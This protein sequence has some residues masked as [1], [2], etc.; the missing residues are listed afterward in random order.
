MAGQVIHTVSSE[1]V[2]NLWITGEIL[3]IQIAELALNNTVGTAKAA[4]LFKVPTILTTVAEKSFSGPILPEIKAVFPNEPIIDRTTM[5]TWEDQRVRD[6][7][8][9]IGK[10]KLVIAGLWTE[11]CVVYPVVSAIEDGYDVYFISDASGATSME[12]HNMAIQRMVQSGAKPLT[13]LQ[14]LLE[15]QRDWARGATYNGVAEIAKAHGGAYG[16][17]MFYAKEMFN[18]KEGK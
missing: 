12:A 8:K 5:N 14:Y 15:L 10:K 18:A 7:V 9:K 4:K 3:T 16:L 11:V 1:K 13:W 2:E 6:A 17:G